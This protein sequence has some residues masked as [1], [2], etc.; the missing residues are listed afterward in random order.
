MDE[1]EWKFGII[2]MDFKLIGP[3]V[4]TWGILGGKGHW[5]HTWED[6]QGEEVTARREIFLLAEY[7]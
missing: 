2:K 6:V 7:T 4:S 3:A 5:G 1:K